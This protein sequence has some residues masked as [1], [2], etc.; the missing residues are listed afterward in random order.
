MLTQRENVNVDKIQL[1]LNFGNKV[2]KLIVHNIFT[3]SINNLTESAE[4]DIE[5][6]DPTA[7][8]TYGDIT[9]DT[10]SYDYSDAG[11]FQPNKGEIIMINSWQG[12][13]IIM[14]VCFITV[15]WIMPL[16]TLRRLVRFVRDLIYKPTK[17]VV[18]EAEKEWENED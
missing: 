1:A 14:V 13:L 15:K 2:D 12:I 11:I 6:S 4:I 5:I 8:W 9:N 7:N 10:I 16:F 17:K 18:R 3:K